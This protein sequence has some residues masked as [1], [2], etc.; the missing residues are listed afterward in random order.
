[1][2]MAYL[3]SAIPHKSFHKMGWSARVLLIFKSRSTVTLAK[4][5]SGHGNPLYITSKN[6]TTM[7]RM[8]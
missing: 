3:A 1:M 5:S 2:K 4:S 8:E 6:S 7:A